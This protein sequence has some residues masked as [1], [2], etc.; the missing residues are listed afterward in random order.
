MS[1]VLSM[2][3]VRKSSRAAG[4][5][6]KAG[7]SEPKWRRREWR[8]AEQAVKAKAEFLSNMSHE[9]RTPM[10][11]IL[12]YA[13][14]R[15]TAL[16]EGNAQSARKYLHNIGLSGK[17]LLKLLNGLLELAKL[18]AG[19]IEYRREPG[20]LAQIVEHSLTD[21]IPSSRGRSSSC[22]PGSGNRSAVR[23]A[24][25]GAGAHQYSLERHQ[26][27]SAKALRFQCGACG[28]ALRPKAAPLSCRIVD[29]RPGIPKAD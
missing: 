11:A 19:K 12:G 7:A 27:L 16:A 1:R 10:H 20:D 22:A 5:S 15:V 17:R 23:Q 4:A 8:R 9:L 29:E 26:V 2:F 6:R 3:S 13:E 18:N 21:S 25:H 14:I 28:R 24:P